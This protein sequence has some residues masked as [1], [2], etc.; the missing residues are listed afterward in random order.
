MRLHSTNAGANIHLVTANKVT[1]D[2]LE[3][4]FTMLGERVTTEIS[5]NEKPKG[6]FENK[7]VA[8]RGG[9]VAGDARENTEK[10]IGRSIISEENY[11]SEKS[12]GSLPNKNEI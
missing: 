8:K 6:M 12:K 4:I 10:E 7:K 9:K 5:Q 2:D 3:L 1:K 11:L